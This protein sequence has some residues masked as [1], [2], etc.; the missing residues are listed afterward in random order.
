L[1]TAAVPYRWLPQ[2]LLLLAGI[3]PY[4]VM[5]VLYA[6]QRMP[7]PAYAD[8]IRVLTIWGRTKKGRPLVVT[9]RMVG[10]FD[11]LIVGAWEMSADELARFEE[12]EAGQ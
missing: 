6:E 12:W 9:V 2:A 5:Q 11:Q 10:R 7:V 4:E 3:E 8:G 1:Y